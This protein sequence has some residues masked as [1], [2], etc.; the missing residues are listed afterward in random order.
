M[1]GS[2]GE[3]VKNIQWYKDRLYEAALKYQNSLSDSDLIAYQEF[4]RRCNGILTPN[5]VQSILVRVN[6][7]A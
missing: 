2:P 3:I 6:Q 1:F 4:Q 7:E 5:E